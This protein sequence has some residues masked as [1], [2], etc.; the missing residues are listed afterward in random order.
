M[1]VN[2]LPALE[3]KMYREKEGTTVISNRDSE[4]STSI[5]ISDDGITLASNNISSGISTS[6]NGVLLQG[7]ILFTSKGTSIKKSNYSE[8]PNSAKI[9][10]YTETI[11]TEADAKEGLA[12]IAGK[13]GVNTGDLTKEGIVPL[14][15]GMPIGAG[16]ILPH[17]HAMLFEHVHRVEP[18]Y[19]YRVPAVLKSFSGAM[20]SIFNFFQTLG[21]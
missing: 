19:L 1:S 4:E 15:T 10:T 20:D 14:L 7:D 18:A 11:S 2:S 17:T 9:F 5:I 16:T 6:N 12:S 13:L 3:N 8:N 21:S